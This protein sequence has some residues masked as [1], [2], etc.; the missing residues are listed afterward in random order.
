MISSLSQARKEKKKKKKEALTQRLLRKLAPREL[1]LHQLVCPAQSRSHITRGIPHQFILGQ[2]LGGH[3]S[4]FS[5]GRLGEKQVPL[6]PL[7]SFCVLLCLQ[8]S[9]SEIASRPDSITLVYHSGSPPLPLR[10]KEGK[11]NLLLQIL[12]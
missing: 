5:L 3:L 12:L 6:F 4:R 10:M 2:F 11:K 8:L 1:S 9:V 7:R